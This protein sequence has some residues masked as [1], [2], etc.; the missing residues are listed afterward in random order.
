MA[1]RGD[2]HQHAPWEVGPEVSGKTAH[3]HSLFLSVNRWRRVEAVPGYSAG[4]SHI[5]LLVQRLPATPTAPVPVLPSAFPQE[6][7]LGA[8]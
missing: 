7:G 3:M 2:G 6:K 5:C 8:L 4:W 1:G